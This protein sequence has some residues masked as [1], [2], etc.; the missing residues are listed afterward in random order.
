MIVEQLQDYGN[1]VVDTL[2]VELYDLLSKDKIE[3]SGEL[4]NLFYEQYYSNI[5]DDV[6]FK[7]ESLEKDDALQDESDDVQV[8]FNEVLK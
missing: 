8:K 1:E 2:A 3:E 7:T 4:I 6:E 5:K